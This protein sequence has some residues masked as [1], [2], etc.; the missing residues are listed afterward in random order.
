[1]PLEWDIILLIA[2]SVAVELV[3]KNMALQ[4]IN[5]VALDRRMTRTC[6]AFML[7]TP[8]YGHVNI[9]KTHPT[10]PRNSS[11]GERGGGGGGGVWARILQGGGGGRV[12]VRGNF[13]I[14]QAKTTTSEWVFKPPT[15]PPPGSATVR[16]FSLE[17]LPHSDLQVHDTVVEVFINQ[18]IY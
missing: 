4:S 14:L 7:C 18:S 8:P 10:G 15:P 12:Q 6:K 3:D 13:H 17:K 2:L 16:C 9:R 11:R 1:M 5:D